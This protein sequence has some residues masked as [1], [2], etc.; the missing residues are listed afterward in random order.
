MFALHR[1]R[2][3]RCR[4]ICTHVALLWLS[5][6][7]RR[8]RW[9]GLAPLHRKVVP[10]DPH[11]GTF[12]RAAAPSIGFVG[13]SAHTTESLHRPHMIA[14]TARAMFAPF[15]RPPPRLRQ[16][17]KRCRPRLPAAQPQQQPTGCRWQRRSLA[18]TLYCRAPCLL[19]HL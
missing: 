11:R 2:C 17:Q 12:Q 9:R 14:K 13:R 16:L 5:L 19:P 10:S 15:T 1:R 8:N 7:S 3:P 6:R 4:S 18:G